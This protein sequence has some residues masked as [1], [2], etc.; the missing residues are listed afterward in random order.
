MESGSSPSPTIHGRCLYRS[1]DQGALYASVLMVSCLHCVGLMFPAYCVRQESCMTTG[2]RTSALLDQRYQE[3]TKSLA[4]SPWQMRL[5]RA[6]RIVSVGT[7]SASCCKD[8]LTPY[9]KR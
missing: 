7:Y 8:G 5:Y 3:S 9:R 1:I 2:M 4:E 6:W